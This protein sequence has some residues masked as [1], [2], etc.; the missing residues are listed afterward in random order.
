MFVR[1]KIILMGLAGAAAPLFGLHAQPRRLVEDRDDRVRDRERERREH[2]EDERREHRRDVREREEHRP[3]VAA[4]RREER[5][6]APDADDL[7][8]REV[9]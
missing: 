1:R 9:R 3:V 6:L 2:M 5:R 4:P 8:R 7:R